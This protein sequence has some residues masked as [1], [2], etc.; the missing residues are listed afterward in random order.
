MFTCIFEALVY[1]WHKWFF[2]K[3]SHRILPPF[4]ILSRFRYLR[5]TGGYSVILG[6]DQVCEVRMPTKV[7]PSVCAHMRGTGVIQQLLSQMT[8]LA[9][10]CSM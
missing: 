2:N 6:M 9:Q 3:H 4:C 1:L 7:N 5:H 8:H 10:I